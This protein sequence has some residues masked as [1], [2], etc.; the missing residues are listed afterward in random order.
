MS[1]RRDAT[2]LLSV[3]NGKSLIYDGGGPS[4]ALKSVTGSGSVSVTNTA[5]T[6]NLAVT[7]VTATSVGAGVSLVQSGAGPALAFRSLVA[8]SG[9]TLTQNANDITVVNGGPFNFTAPLDITGTTGTA[10][11]ENATAF[12]SFTGTARQWI[13]SNLGAGALRAGSSAPTFEEISTTGL[14]ANNFAP[15]GGA[16]DE[17]HGTIDIPPGYCEG[18]NIIFH[19]HVIPKTD[20]GGP[21]TNIWE[22]N[23]RWL[24]GGESITGPTAIQVTDNLVAGDQLKTRHVAFAAISGAG[25]TIGTLFKFRLRRKSSLDTY[26]GGSYVVS[27]GIHFLADTIGA[28]APET[29]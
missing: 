14:W 19:F 18:T 15:G 28:H 25:K 21:V 24:A 13:D 3:G 20:P 16:E 27:V 26:A 11:Y 4:A 9:I 1:S 5:T 7:P 6:V 8:G 10:H 23:Y 2:S 29:K 17:L 12:L 22:L